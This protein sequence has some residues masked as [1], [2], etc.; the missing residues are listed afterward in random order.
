M[1][2]LLIIISSSLAAGHRPAGRPIVIS[3]RNSPS[4]VVLK[5]EHEV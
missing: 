4:A 3:M 5:F 2:A 1:F